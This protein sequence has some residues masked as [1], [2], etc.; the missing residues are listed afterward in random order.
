MRALKQTTLRKF[1]LLT[2][3]WFLSFTPCGAQNCIVEDWSISIVSNDMTS[4]TVQQKKVLTIVNQQGARHAAFVC[5]CSK[6]NK[7]GSFHGKVTDG[8]GQVVRE[9]KKSELLRTEYSPYL[10]V[11]DYK[12]YYDYTPPTFPVHPT[13]STLRRMVAGWPASSSSFSR[14]LRTFFKPSTA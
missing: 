9:I 10:A 1:L 14:K 13:S 2:L 4:M 7:L 8:S 5:S 6:K 3:L 12:M 11:D